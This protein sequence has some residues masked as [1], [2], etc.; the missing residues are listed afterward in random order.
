MDE[1]AQCR[2]C[3]NELAEYR[4]GRRACCLNATP[5]EGICPEHG[6]VGPHYVE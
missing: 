4:S 3:G 2:L 5:I 1:D 6:P